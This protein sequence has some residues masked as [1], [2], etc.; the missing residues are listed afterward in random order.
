MEETDSAIC[1]LSNIHSLVNE[2]VYLCMYVFFI[3]LNRAQLMWNRLAADPK[4]ATLS[5]CKVF[6]LALYL[7]SGAR[8]RLSLNKLTQNSMSQNFSHK[9]N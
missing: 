3:T 1:T 8:H 6:N 4:D 7:L 2:V 9:F 5:R